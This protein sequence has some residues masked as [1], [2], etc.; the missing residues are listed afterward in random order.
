MRVLVIDN[1]DSFTFNLVHHLGELG[2]DPV[3][4]RN[5][6]VTADGAS[7][8][9]PRSHRRSRPV[10]HAPTTPGIC[11]EVIRRSPAEIP[12]LGVCLGHQASPWPTA[13]RW[14]GRPSCHGKVSESPTTARGSSAGC[15]NP[16]V[17]TRYH[18]LVDESTL[19]DVLQ[20]TARTDDGLIRGCATPALPLYG[21]QFHPESVMTPEGMALLKN[22]LQG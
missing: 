6:E 2:A 4:V 20:V 5:D 11:V 13:A 14:F 3:V 9:R 12:I 7:T 16:L 15:P 10:R 1:Y 8:A 18:S 22:F 19:P 21:V 17:A